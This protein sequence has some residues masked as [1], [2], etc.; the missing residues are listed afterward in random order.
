MTTPLLVPAPL[1][2]EFDTGKAIRFGPGGLRLA[3]A[4]PRDADAAL[5]AGAG[6]LASATG[7]DVEVV[8]EGDGR[9]NV[10]YVLDP[11]APRVLDPNAQ[12]PTGA[13][14]YELVVGAEGARI[15]ARSPAGFARATATLAQVMEVDGAGEARAPM[16]VVRDAPRFPW[17]GLSLDVA[18]SFFPVAEVKTVL[19]LLY[20]YKLN[21]LHL[22]LTD[23]Q[24]W[25]LEIPSRPELTEIS[26][27]TAVDGGRPG[28]YTV[29]DFREIQDYA[30]AHSI[31]VVPEIDL[32]GHTNAATHAVAEL[33]PDGLPT[34]AYSGMR[35]G[36]SMLHPELDATEP[37]LRDVIG[38]VAGQTRDGFVHFGGDE[39]LDMDP[40]NYQ[41]LV[42][43][44]QTI[45][46][47][48]GKRPVAWQE[49][50]AAPP[51]PSTI[52]QFWDTR[53]DATP[54]NGAVAAG[55]KVILSPGSRT[56]MDMKYDEGEALGQDWAGL[57]ALGDS[58]AWEPATFLEGV[59][60]DDVVGV[61]AAVWTE[62][63]HNLEDLTYMLLPRIVAVAELGWS[64]KHALNWE[65][66]TDRLAWQ[67][68]VW[69]AAG[70]SWHR[71]PEVS[72]GG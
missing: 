68:E 60:E 61:E 31:T 15:T 48:N 55:A 14:A 26:G 45:V 51:S 6:F 24:G 63:L 16:G 7:L 13:E 36:F 21:V 66:F 23:D 30:E 3:L 54:V 8:N 57:V 67:G 39:P 69:D 4:Q 32:P 41:Q 64:P 1:F 2:S 12:L 44:I 34:A 49:A 17:R 37:F 72:W 58:Y 52:Y 11:K 9:A 71:S 10:M 5:G 29:E 65:S 70:L 18:R 19:D 46:E 53:P 50:A 43:L 42:T 33:N 62:T 20:S 56:Y 28:F 22:H 25:R 38:S 27:A 35:V 47:E 40:G 59:G